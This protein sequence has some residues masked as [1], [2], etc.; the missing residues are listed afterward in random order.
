MH[1][2]LDSTSKQTSESS[3]AASCIVCGANTTEVFHHI[4]RVP[5]QCN[6]LWTSRSEALNA[7]TGSITLGFCS[8]CGHIFNV[9]YDPEIMEYD[10]RYENSL[11]F[12]ARFRAYANALIRELDDLYSLSGKHVVDVG[13]G[14]GDFLKS[15]CAETKCSGYGFDQSYEPEWF[16]ISHGDGLIEFFPE[17]Y[18][19]SFAHVPVNL[20]TCRHVLEH[21]ENPYSFVSMI[22]NTLGNRNQ[23]DLFFEVPNALYTL[24]QLGI[25][26]IIYEHVS[27]FTEGS[28]TTLF[29]RVGFDVR[30]VNPAFEGQFLALHAHHDSTTELANSEGI[31]HTTMLDLTDDVRRFQDRYK[32]KIDEWSDVLRS[33]QQSGNRMVIWGSGSKGVTFLNS[34]GITW[35][36]PYAVDIN[37]RKHGLFIPGTAQQV[38][39]PEFLGEFRPDI[40]VIMNRI[41]EDEI[42]SQLRALGLTTEVLSA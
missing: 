20:L 12:S 5:V 8:S 19:E 13:C 1:V 10:P 28:L 29:N 23:V 35:S 17:F 37:P 2:E 15:L 38:V 11:H 6:V 7:P 26:D 4:E 42:R 31:D 3:R 33:V 32:A 14:R 24:R 21:I 25:W 36:I 22:R 34:L 18:D 39:P 30:R 27:Y 40:V 16:D 9:D 41:Y